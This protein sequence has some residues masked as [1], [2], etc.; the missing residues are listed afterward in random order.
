[1]HRKGARVILLTGDN[2]E[3]ANAVARDLGIREI[4]AELKLDDLAPEA[5]LH[6][7]DGP[8]NLVRLTQ[9]IDQ[10]DAD[11]LRA[12]LAQSRPRQGNAKIALPTSGSGGLKVT[13]KPDAAVTDGAVS[14]VRLSSTTT[15]EALTGTLEA[16]DV[17]VETLT[18]GIDGGVADVDENNV[19]T[20]TVS[21]LPLP[22][23]QVVPPSSV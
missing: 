23:S 15:D 6:R 17:D 4:E 3:V 12:A 20:G 22:V 1:M 8:V 9:L 16:S 7:V 11:A 21:V 10:A 13:L 19:P 5:A 18:Y 14:E 2:A